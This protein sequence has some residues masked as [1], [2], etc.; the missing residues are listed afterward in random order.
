[1]IKNDLK[2]QAL[3]HGDIFEQLANDRNIDINEAR[4][5]VANMSFKDYRKFLEATLAQP[6]NSFSTVKPT[7]PNPSQVKQTPEVPDDDDADKAGNPLLRQEDI[8]PPSGQTIGPSSQSGNTAQGATATNTTATGTS[9]SWPGKGTPPQV[10]MTVSVKGPNG[11][12]VP[13]QVSQVDMS[14]KGVKVKNPT[15]G[16]DEW[17]NIDA[18]EPFM[19]Q[20]NPNQQQT[21]QTQQAMQPVQQQAMEDANDLARLRTL[22]G[23]KENCSAGATGASSIAISPTSMTAPIKRRSTLDSMKKEYEPKE[24]AKT[25]VGDTKPNQASG[26]L[27]ANLAVRGKKTASR[28]NNGFKK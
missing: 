21:Q 28:T 17:T 7:Y 1:M 9:A 23:I 16:Q 26:E 12:P 19:A 27:S 10:G 8:I 20:N 22:A 2:I 6:T 14:S 5:I 4:E 25:I 24:A 3:L 11:V 13:G 18:L 15:T